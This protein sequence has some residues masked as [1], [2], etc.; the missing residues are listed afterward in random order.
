MPTV[1]GYGAEL[2]L[3][4][5]LVLNAA[6]IAGAYR[7]ARRRLSTGR[8]QAL[9]DAAL[10]A[11][12]IQYLAVG[13]PGLLGALS[14][15]SMTL[16]AL[17][18]STLLWVLSYR[19][20]E[21][22]TP[23]ETNDQD[24]SIIVAVGLFAVT[25]VF[26]FARFQRLLPVMSNDAMT[27]HF[28]A[29]VQWLQTGRIGLFQT[30]FFNPANT[31]SPLAGSTFIA[32]LLAPFGNDLL[33]RF[34]EIPA[35]LFV[36]L[37]LFQLC[38]LLRVPI[39]IAVIV[40][41]S[42]VLSRPL[43]S[44]GMMGKDDLFVTAF[45]L[46]ALIAMSPDRAGDRFAP[47]RLGVAIGLL[48]ATKYTVL[49]S[50]PILLLA[51]DGPWRAGWRWQQW[52]IAKGIVLAFAGPW[53]VRNILLAFN[54]LFPID[55]RIA[56]VKILPGLFSP[57]H[58]D[59]LRSLSGIGDVLFG[60]NYGLPPLLALLVF[61]AW[62]ILAS[63]R[64]QQIWR[65]PLLRCCVIGPIIGLGLFIWRSPFPEVRFA[66]PCFVLLFAAFAVAVGSTKTWISLPLSLVLLATSIATQFVSNAAGEVL[67]FIEVSLIIAAVGVLFDHLTR[68]IPLSRRLLW[69][70]VPAAIAFSLLIYINWTAYVIGYQQSLFVDLGAWSLKYPAEVRLWR[71][72]NDQIPPDAT[73]AYTNTYM[74]YPLQG[75]TLR[76][77]VI[78]A[79]TQP[80][81]QS[82]A[83]LRYL[84]DHISGERLPAIA[85]AATVANADRATWLN[86]L[87]SAGADYLLIAKSDRVSQ[88]PEVRFVAQMPRRFVRIYDGEA[89]DVYSIDWSIGADDK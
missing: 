63:I 70:G 85:S 37:A 88:P 82:L 56:G 22:K 29:A 84:G 15:M 46:C 49:F 47:V 30:W 48:L 76:R 31:Y 69:F 52:T 67:T 7:F 18:L 8:G 35:L 87:K 23:V 39:I 60:G 75:P 43:F 27:Y 9:L 10:F 53:Y 26:A 24:R 78:Y 86:N 33:A 40:A 12:A 55:V 81:V 5:C 6:V 14:P 42:A 59:G 32:W 80:G 79:P 72:V 61:V 62:I 34:V 3:G 65:D 36:G 17:L 50:L 19:S 28:P 21:S 77:R 89:G 58:S 38:R 68:K 51:I 73:L 13:I 57:A 45:F 44:Q 66:F 4:W 74:V 20:R 25:Y 71:F 2:S 41:A 11:Y 54:P 64:H 83:D 1:P 16:V